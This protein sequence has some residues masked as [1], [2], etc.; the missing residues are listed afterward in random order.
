M[1]GQCKC[2]LEG[3]GTVGRGDAKPGNVEATCQKHRPNVEMGKNAVE[4]EKQLIYNSNF[5]LTLKQVC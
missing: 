2:G 5:K 4:E 1:G 3:E